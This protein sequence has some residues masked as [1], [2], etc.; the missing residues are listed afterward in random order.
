MSDPFN[1]PFLAAADLPT[2]A[3]RVRRR[4]VRNWRAGGW[5]INVITVAV[6]T[7]ELC[8]VCI[9]PG[10]IHLVSMKRISGEGG[11]LGARIC[12]R[13]LPEKGFLPG[14]HLMAAMRTQREDGD[15]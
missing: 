10:A 5:K 12:D 4:E 15:D 6:D 11:S 9:R 7:D 1:V 13:H 3:P 2:E 14:E 8:D